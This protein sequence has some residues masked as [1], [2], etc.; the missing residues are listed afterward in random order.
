MSICRSTKRAGSN[1][2]ANP[3]KNM[4]ALAVAQALHVADEVRYLHTWGDM[5]RAVRKLWSMRSVASAV[6]LTKQPK[7]VGAMR[8]KLVDVAEKNPRLA[9]Y[10]IHV[11]G[12]VLLIN[13]DGTT[14]V[15]TAPRKRDRRKVLSVYGVYVDPKK[16]D[17]L[18]VKIEAKLRELRGA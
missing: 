7:T 16:V 9:H 11:D 1:N 6:G 5:E 8:K 14:S 15:D 17:R 4:C 3:N 18:Q 12:H 10:V 13:R 2:P